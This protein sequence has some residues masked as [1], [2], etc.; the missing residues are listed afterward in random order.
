MSKE[1]AGQLLVV[2]EGVCSVAPHMAQQ[3][4]SVVLRNVQ[5]GHACDSFPETGGRGLVVV[6]EGLVVVEEVLAATAM[7]GVTGVTGGTGGTGGMVAGT[8]AGVLVSDEDTQEMGSFSGKHT[9]T[10]CFRGSFLF[11]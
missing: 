11:G 4:A 8:L 6:A 2:D 7:V 10:T 1:Q 9:T 3:G 5:V